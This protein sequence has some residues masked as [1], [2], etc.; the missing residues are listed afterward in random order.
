VK[1]NLTFLHQAVTLCDTQLYVCSKETVTLFTHS[2]CKTRSK[3]HFHAHMI[4]KG[5]HIQGAAMK[6]P[7][8][9]YCSTY[10]EPCDFVV[11]KTCLC[12]F[13]LAPVMISTH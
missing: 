10:K 1:I 9:F 6:S 8:L 7:E 4:S 11:I 3:I 5:T 12:M 2:I 13:Q